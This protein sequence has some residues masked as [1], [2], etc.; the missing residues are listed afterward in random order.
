VSVPDIKRYSL[1]TDPGT[2]LHT[3]CQKYNRGNIHNPQHFED[4]PPFK[5]QRLIKKNLHSFVWFELM[6]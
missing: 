4:R 6:K 5:K 2:H 3:G 1:G